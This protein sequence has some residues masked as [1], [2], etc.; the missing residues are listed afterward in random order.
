MGVTLLFSIF[1]GNVI[2][3]KLQVGTNTTVAVLVNNFTL[4]FGFHS[5]VDITHWQI[6]C[7][8][9]AGFHNRVCSIQNHGHNISLHMLGLFINQGATGFITGNNF[10]IFIQ[11]LCCFEFSIVFV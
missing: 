1:I 2:T 7:K 3:D 9:F 11:V 10:D 8:A 6:G 5:A 4:P